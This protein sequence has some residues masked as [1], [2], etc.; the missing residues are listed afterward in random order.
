VG[1]GLFLDSGS[2]HRQPLYGDLLSTSPTSARYDCNGSTLATALAAVG[3]AGTVDVAITDTC[4]WAHDTGDYDIMIDAEA[5][6]VTAIGAVSGT[7]PTRTQTLTVTRSAN[8]VTAAHAVG[9]EIHVRYRG[10]YAL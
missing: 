2:I 7:Y 8:G 10:R 6:T 5:I 3:G 9:A 4:V 1:A